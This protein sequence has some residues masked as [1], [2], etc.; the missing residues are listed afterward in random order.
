MNAYRQGNPLETIRR[1]KTTFQ[2]V[3][4]VRRCLFFDAIEMMDHCT[5]LGKEEAE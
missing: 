4:G 3:A 5:L 2:E 1:E